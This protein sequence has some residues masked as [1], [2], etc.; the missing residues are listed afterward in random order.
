MLLSDKEQILQFDEMPTPILPEKDMIW[1]VSHMKLEA[2]DGI[3]P[4]YT[5][6][7]SAA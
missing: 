2:E 4:P 1:Q 3:E 5:D 7:Q 6:L